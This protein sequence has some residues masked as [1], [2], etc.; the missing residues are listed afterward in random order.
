MK[1]LKKFN[2]SKSKFQEEI[3]ILKDITLDLKDS[4][5][6]VTVSESDDRFHLSDAIFLKI[7][8]DDKIFCKKWPENDM[9][10]L[11]GKPIIMEFYKTLEGFNLKWDRDYV[12]AGGGP[13]V[14]LIFKGKNRESIK[15]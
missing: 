3:E 8:D 11:H 1:H 5:L 12:I 2:E 6:K 13:S 10:W 4:G 15:L 7:E 9:D 14:T